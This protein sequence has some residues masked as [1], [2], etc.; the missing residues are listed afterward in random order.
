MKIKFTDGMEF[1]LSGPLRIERQSD[2]LY[3]VG[4]GQLI[5]VANVEEGE[6]IIREC[7]PARE[8]TK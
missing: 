1:N 3:V 2:G 5:P 8:K 6:A 7:K 4:E